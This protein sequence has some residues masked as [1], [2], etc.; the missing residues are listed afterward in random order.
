MD[1][2]CPKCNISFKDAESYFYKNSSRYDGLDWRCKKCKRS[3]ES[4]LRRKY[5]D[6]RRYEKDKNKILARSK[7]Q[8]FYRDLKTKCAVITCNETTVDL[9]H[10]D[11]DLPLDVIPVCHHHHVELHHKIIREA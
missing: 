9:H 10:F 4:G 5:R 3:L 1:K 6:A 7:A 8:H 2:K 11:Y